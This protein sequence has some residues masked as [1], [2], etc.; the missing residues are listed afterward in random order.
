MF[1]E[2]AKYFFQIIFKAYTTLIYNFI[3][4]GD[5]RKLTI[6]ESKWHI[7]NQNNKHSSDI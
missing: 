2:G 5:S 3:G 4:Q 7:K 6:I 1:V